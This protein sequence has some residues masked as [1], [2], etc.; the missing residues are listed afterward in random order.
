MNSLRIESPFTKDKISGLKV[1]DAVSITGRVFTG[2]DRFHKF[3]CEGGKAPADL[4]DGAIYHCGPVMLRK[5]GAWTAVAAG[6]TTSVREEPYTPS[7]IRR[8]GIRLILGK[9]GM[10]DGTRRAC[11]ESGCAYVH[12]VGG[13]ACLLAKKIVSVDRVYFLK[14]FGPAEA[15]WELLVKDISGI[16][17]ID[18]RGNSLHARILNGTRRAMRRLLA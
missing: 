10:G 1:G 11:R 14:E 12:L 7:I 4:K 9:G 15:V 2:R 18:S 5:D 3:L 6:P 17:T 13:A 8:H 16:V